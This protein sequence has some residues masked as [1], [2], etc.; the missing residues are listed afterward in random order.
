MPN[1]NEFILKTVI[2]RVGGLE[3]FLRRR[4]YS[5]LNYGKSRVRY[6]KLRQIQGLFGFPLRRGFKSP[7]GHFFVNRK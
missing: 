5:T 4:A 6:F 7:L 1:K 3:F 2:W